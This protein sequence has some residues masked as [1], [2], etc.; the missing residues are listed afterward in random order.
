LHKLVGAADI[1]SFDWRNIGVGSTGYGYQAYKPPSFAAPELN[2][3]HLI[4]SLAQSEVCL[5][6]IVSVILELRNGLQLDLEVVAN[7]Q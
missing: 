1:Y 5:L 2:R 3:S 4:P 6:P 7:K